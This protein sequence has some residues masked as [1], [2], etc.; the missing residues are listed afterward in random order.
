MVDGFDLIEEEHQD[1]ADVQIQNPGALPAADSKVP[2]ALGIP[3]LLIGLIAL[4]LSLTPYVRADRAIFGMISLPLGA[5]GLLLGLGALA[6][7]IMRKGQ[8]IG[9]PI[10]GAAA[11]LVAVAVAAVGLVWPRPETRPQLVAEP[12][13]PQ[14]VARVEDSSKEMTTPPETKGPQWVDASKGIV[15]FYDLRVKVDKVTIG[16]VRVQS[17]LEG[18]TETK[19]QYL[20]IH[21]LVGNAGTAK[22]FDY[23]GWSGTTPTGSV[24]DLLKGLT[25]EGGGLKEVMGAVSKHAASLSDDIGNKYKTIKLETGDEIPGQINAETPI[26]PNETKGDLLVFQRPVDTIKYLRLEL[27]GGACGMKETLYLQIPKSMIQR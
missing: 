2:T 3:A 17:I 25:G 16:T 4:M 5:L 13:R 9:F 23:R 7:A 8:G 26:Y 22:K 18:A 24:D 20:H 21:L 1:G 10:A 12:E 19:A 15:P 14:D 6:V 27:P 11:N